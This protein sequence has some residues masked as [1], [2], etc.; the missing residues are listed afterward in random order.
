MRMMLQTILALVFAGL[1]YYACGNVWVAL[2]LGSCALLL[3]SQLERE[4]K[5][6]DVTHRKDRKKNRRF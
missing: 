5:S 2:G 6:K 4:Y 1:V 3:V